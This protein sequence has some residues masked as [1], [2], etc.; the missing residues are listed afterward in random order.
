MDIHIWEGP[1]AP[2][3]CCCGVKKFTILKMADSYAEGTITAVDHIEHGIVFTEPWE[4]TADEGNRWKARRKNDETAFFRDEDGRVYFTANSE[5]DASM[6]AFIA[7]RIKV[8]LE[9]KQEKIGPIKMDEND[10]AKALQEMKLFKVG[11]SFIF[12]AQI[13]DD[14]VGC[15]G[16]RCSNCNN[17]A[18]YCEQRCLWCGFPFIGPSGFPQFPE[19][20]ALSLAIKK[21]LVE[22]TYMRSG[23]GRLGYSNVEFVPLTSEE[24][25]LI[26]SLS[27]RD[28]EHFLSAHSISPREIR[29]TLF[30]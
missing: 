17:M 30:E 6:E 11:S 1:E 10:R 18:A 21:E 15:S 22:D 14:S 12:A 19:W 24:L 3:A 8:Y 5:V 16:S 7:E 23:K 4:A 13:P 26:E 9:T 28:V 2:L 29:S 20:K 25:H 27:G